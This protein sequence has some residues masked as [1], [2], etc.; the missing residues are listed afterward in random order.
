MP[1]GKF[2][3]DEWVAYFMVSVIVRGHDESEMVDDVAVEQGKL[4]E[5]GYMNCPLL[6]VEKRRGYIH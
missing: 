5:L 1:Q 3:K 6:N 4:R 2:P